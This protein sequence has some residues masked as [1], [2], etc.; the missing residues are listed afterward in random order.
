MSTDN[1]V[2]TI[3]ALVDGRRQWLDYQ[4][5]VIRPAART[6]L[7]VDAAGRWTVEVTTDN[8]TLD[9]IVDRM[10]DFGIVDGMV[11]DG[12]GSSQWYDGE[13]RLSG[14]GRVVFSYLVLWFDEGE[15]EPEESGESGFTPTFGVDVSDWQGKIDWEAAKAAAC[16]SP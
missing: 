3:L 4:A 15:T 7:G 10:E 12:S 11:F 13:T 8:Y 6:W 1:F 9:G 2:S 14:D 16:S 5:G